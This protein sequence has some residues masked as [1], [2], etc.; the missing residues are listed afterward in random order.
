MEGSG[1]GM[2]VPLRVTACGLPV[3]LWVMLRDALRA[4]ATLG[5][6]CTCSVQELPADRDV[7]LVQV[8]LPPSAYS[9]DAAPEKLNAVRLKVDVPLLVIVV[10]ALLLL[11]TVALMLR[12]A[13]PMLNAG[14]SPC[15]TARWFASGHRW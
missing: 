6:N 9:A 4:P 8:L 15:R 1:A 7:A 13:E 10:E 11:P 2:A 5:V 3:A 12:V 14:A